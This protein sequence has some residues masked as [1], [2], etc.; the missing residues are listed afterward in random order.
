[1]RKN[2]NQ[3][4][5]R[6]FLSHCLARAQDP[7]GQQ[8]FHCHLPYVFEEEVR[9]HL[10]RINGVADLFV[11]GG[12]ESKCMWWWTPQ[13]LASYKLTIDSIISVLKS[14]NVTVSAGTMGVGRRDFRIRTL[15]NFF[16]LR[17]S[18]TW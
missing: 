1:M 7:A 10:E 4:H 14:E 9:Q 2:R 18:K 11:F 5:W 16:L 13:K 17:T 6:L 8:A 15:A 3:R 12:T